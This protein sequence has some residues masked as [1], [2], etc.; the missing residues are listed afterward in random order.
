GRERVAGEIR[1]DLGEIADAPVSVQDSRLFAAA[2]AEA[3]ELHGD[4]LKGFSVWLAQRAGGS[5]VGRRPRTS[6]VQ[7][8]PGNWPPSISK[9]WPVI[10]PAWAEHRNAQAAP[11]SSGV[12]KRFAGTEA[13][14][15]A[16]AWSTEMPCFL[17]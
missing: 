11:N 13:A 10:K 15:A 3:Q 7:N 4:L 17:A 16:V 2:R 12:P 6:A 14:R 8:A 5:C 1:H 9:F